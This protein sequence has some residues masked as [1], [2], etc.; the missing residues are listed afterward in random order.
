ML[1]F[2]YGSNMDRAQMKRRCPG[3]VALGPARLADW[4]FTVTCDG[5]ASIVPHPG[6]TVHGVLWH[7]TPRDLAAVNAYESLDS[8]LYRRRMLTVR[9]G[10]GSVQALVYV[11]LARGAGRP[12]PGYQPLVVAAARA[13][14]LPEAYVESL[15]RFAPGSR[16]TARA[17]ETGEVA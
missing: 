9:A 10:G 3:A 7:L 16:G 11:A 4:R 8:G 2:A 13:W 12:R 15:A 1:H 17:V 14:S 5:Y 6:V